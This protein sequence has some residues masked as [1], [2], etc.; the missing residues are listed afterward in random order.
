LTYAS[1]SASDGDSQLSL[2]R[3]Q[4]NGADAGIPR[5]V[6]YKPRTSFFSKPVHGIG[7]VA[8]VGVS[9]STG[10]INYEQFT[11]PFTSDYYHND[12]KRNALSFSFGLRYSYSLFMLL[13]FG[14]SLTYNRLGT[15]IDNS[16][17]LVGGTQN[18][19][20]SE[21]LKLDYLI[22][23][24]YFRVGV[25]SLGFYMGYLLKAKL[26]SSD[27]YDKFKKIDFGMSVAIDFTFPTEKNDS[28]SVILEGL[29]GFLNIY[30][31][32]SRTYRNLGFQFKLAYIFGVFKK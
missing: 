27:V 18:N 10:S 4:A 19:G 11:S 30:D 2:V 7:V 14:A 21:V 16:Y 22:L 26:G 25:L 28:F 23:K 1:Y 24:P 15:E 9:K 6:K 32:F 17:Y 20:F 31:G 29:F 5:N 3:E 12:G 8:G 13:G